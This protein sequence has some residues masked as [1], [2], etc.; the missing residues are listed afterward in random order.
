MIK[1]F[2]IILQ[3]NKIAD[4]SC[5]P[6]EIKSNNTFGITHAYCRARGIMRTPLRFGLRPH[7]PS[8]PPQQHHRSF[9]Y[10]YT[11]WLAKRDRVSPSK[12][13]HEPCLSVS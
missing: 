8:P 6:R 13:T 10:D 11:I 7:S 2:M 1:T 9:L 12:S 3:Y 4:P 5:F